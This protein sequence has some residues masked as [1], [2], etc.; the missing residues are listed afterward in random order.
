MYNKLLTLINPQTFTKLT[1]IYQISGHIGHKNE[2]KSMKIYIA[3]DVY[4]TGNL[5]NIKSWL[6][7]ISNVFSDKEILIS[8]FDEKYASWYYYLNTRECLP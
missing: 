4:T 8:P 2:S 1:F 3:E 7:L 6:F 5:L